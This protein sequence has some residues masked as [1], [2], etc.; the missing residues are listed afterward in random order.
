LID[1]VSSLGRITVALCAVL[2]CATLQTPGAMAFAPLTTGFS[3]PIFM[4]SSSATQAQWIASAAAEHSE[5]I[6]LDVYWSKVARQAPPND[7]QASEPSW[8]GYEWSTLDASVRDATADGM[9]IL[10]TVENA[11]GWA[12][13]PNR[14]SVKI[15]PRGT[16]MPRTDALAAFARAAAERYSGTYIPPGA[17]APLPV[18]RYWQPWN[19]PNLSAYLTPQWEK[20]SAGYKAASPQIYRAMLNAFYK[21]IKSVSSKM[22]VVSAGTAPYGEEPGGK[23]MQPLEFDLELFC[24]SSTLTK[25]PCPDPAQFDILDHHPYSIEGPSFQALNTNDVA[26]ADMPKLIVPLRAAE[27]LHTIRGARYHQVWATE[28]SWDTDPPNPEGV[29]VAT[30]AAWLEETFYLLWREGVSTVTWYQVVD[31]PPIPTYALS[32]EGG[33]HYLSGEP[34]PS[35]QAFLFP[36]ITRRLSRKLV[37]VWGK[38]PSGKGAV[39]IEEQTGSKWRRVAT[40]HSGANGIFEM[41]MK[42]RGSALLRA[43]GNTQLSLAWRQSR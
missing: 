14:P 25:L 17:S 16:W 9:Q 43:R 4:S 13:G 10:V 38:N 11:P 18:V 15:A 21:G 34:K 2:L 6:R 26:I 30:Q 22:L 12:E 27:R 33:T 32:Y 36:F 7:A 28:V 8:S 20:T 24:L 31:A 40:A 37:L 42:L 41:H 29:P 5:I 3:D 39:A 1:L 19:E 23:R 35:A